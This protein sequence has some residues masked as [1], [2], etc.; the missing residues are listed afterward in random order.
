MKKH[1]ENLIEKGF[2][3]EVPTNSRLKKYLY[4]KLAKP[5]YGQEHEKHFLTQHSS[6]I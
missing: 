1:I 3:I 4:H 2:K 6:R 5:F